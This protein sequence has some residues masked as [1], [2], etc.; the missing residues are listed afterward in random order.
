MIEVWIPDRLFGVL[1]RG[2]FG[3]WDYAFIQDGRAIQL[4]RP[5]QCGFAY[6]CCT[7]GRDGSIKVH[8][9]LVTYRLRFNMRSLFRSLDSIYL[10]SSRV[11]SDVDFSL[12]PLQRDQK[13]ISPGRSY[14][15]PKVCCLEA[16]RWSFQPSFSVA[17][18][19]RFWAQPA[20]GF[21]WSQAYNYAWN[22]TVGA[23]GKSLS[24][25]ASAA[26]DVLVQSRYPDSFLERVRSF[27]ILDSDIEVLMLHHVLHV[28]GRSI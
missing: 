3:W 14:V 6:F 15:A 20:G 1:G 19:L 23:L 18:S 22:G 10:A 7:P 24:Q 25:F 13:S 28:A 9:C 11:H 27:I 2:C 16:V 8:M 21:S 4:Y 26:A 5:A 17:L 12:C